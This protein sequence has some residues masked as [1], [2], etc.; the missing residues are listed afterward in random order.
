MV[1]AAGCVEPS[2]ARVLYHYA[3]RCFGGN[4]GGGH[5][6]PHH[7]RNTPSSSPSPSRDDRSLASPPFRA[8]DWMWSDEEDGGWVNDIAAPANTTASEGHHLSVWLRGHARAVHLAA[9]R[10]RDTSVLVLCPSTSTST[11]RDVRRAWGDVLKTRVPDVDALCSAAVPSLNGN[12]VPGFRYLFVDP[13]VGA[14]RATPESKVRPPRIAS[15][16]CT[17]C[18]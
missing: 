5:L 6:S 9:W 10:Y 13:A 11:P 17:W 7:G 18:A 4:G 2:D 3:A 12:H 15:F 8:C 16:L 1:R 14:C